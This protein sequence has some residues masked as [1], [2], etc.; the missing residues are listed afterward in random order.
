[1]NTIEE[2]IFSAILDDDNTEAFRLIS[3]LLPNERQALVSS[4]SKIV[5]LASGAPSLIDELST[6]QG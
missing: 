4:A 1:M 2:A 5:I 6:T 3:T